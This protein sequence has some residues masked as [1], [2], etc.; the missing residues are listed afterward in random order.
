MNKFTLIIVYIFINT[1][2]YGATLTDDQQNKK[3]SSLEAK[4]QQLEQ[5][6]ES[7]HRKLNEQ[8]VIT[9][10][11]QGSTVI[12]GNINTYQVTTKGDRIIIFNIRT[13]YLTELIADYA[14]HSWRV[15]ISAPVPAGAL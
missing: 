4:I 12:P 1:A 8:P 3:I 5:Q 2:C 15:I 6:L 10:I 11:E 14:N 9:S 13:R 7:M